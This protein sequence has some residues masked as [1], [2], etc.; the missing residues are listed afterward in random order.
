MQAAAAAVQA[1]AAVVQADAPVAR[2]GGSYIR[3]VRPKPHPLR[4]C[5]GDHKLSCGLCKLKKVF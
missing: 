1:G 3:L 4:V 2:G 5:Q